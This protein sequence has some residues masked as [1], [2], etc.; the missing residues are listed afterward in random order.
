[1]CNFPL[2]KYRSLVWLTGGAL[3][4]LLIAGGASPGYSAPSL[5]ALTREYSNYT[6]SDADCRNLRDSTSIAYHSR[7]S[8]VYISTDLGCIAEIDANT[9]DVIRSKDL[10]QGV[11]HQLASDGSF[12]YVHTVF[13]RPNRQHKVLKIDPSATTGLSVIRQVTISNATGSPEGFVFLG[14]S[15]YVAVGGYDGASGRLPGKIVKLSKSNLA[16]QATWTI[17]TA[18]NGPN[19]ENHGFTTDGTNLYVLT[20]PQRDRRKD[21][22][23][24]LN[25]S[26]TLLDSHQLSTN[27]SLGGNVYLGGKVYTSGGKLWKLN[28][29]TLAE[30]ASQ[31]CGV[32]WLASD[33][34]YIYRVGGRF[35]G[36]SCT[37]RPDGNVGYVEVVDPNTMSVLLSYRSN[38]AWVFLHYGIV[39]NGFL[40]V[41]YE[42]Q[43]STVPSG[44]IARYR[45]NP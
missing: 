26:L 6:P 3:L 1:M 18:E 22:Y 21:R 16:I 33:S 23:Y 2:A 36:S 13:N 31:G 28:P 32:H 20:V 17:P 41:A 34:T 29:S 12:I 11:A 7:T 24:K 10:N 15:L 14:T 8:K 25:Q 42:G 4:L 27:G 38:P 30:E 35:A 5:S 45:F 40:W 44:R 43:G 19:N 39:A 9:L 37:T